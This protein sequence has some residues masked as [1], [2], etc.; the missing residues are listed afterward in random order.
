VGL[1]HRLAQRDKRLVN[2]RR[3]L[4]LEGSAPAFDIAKT[5]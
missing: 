5:V 4:V 2:I 1:V 3:E